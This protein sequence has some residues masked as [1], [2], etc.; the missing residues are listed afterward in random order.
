VTISSFL[1]LIAKSKKIEIQSVLELKTWR[2]FGQKIFS[3]CIV[4]A[5]IHHI[6][7]ISKR[8]LLI[9]HSVAT[10]SHYSLRAK[11]TEK[12]LFIITNTKKSLPFSFLSD[13]QKFHIIPRGLKIK[14]SVWVT[15]LFRNIICRN[16]FFGGAFVC[17]RYAVIISNQY[18]HPY[19]YEHFPSK[20]KA[21][22]KIGAT[23][24]LHVAI[25][26]FFGLLLHKVVQSSIPSITLYLR[27]LKHPVNGRTFT[28]S[29]SHNVGIICI[30]KKGYNNMQERRKK[31]FFNS[32]L[33]QE[34]GCMRIDTI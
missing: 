10:F 19:I 20:T 14:H 6:I 21:I 5:M 1:V 16:V 9:P 34:E 3:F 2:H 24:I 18:T 17:F 22:R 26:V 23:L 30:D 12:S 27:H 8:L 31:T 28:K 13:Y 29:I 32:N 33:S 11:R 25:C 15:K 4:C 7:Q